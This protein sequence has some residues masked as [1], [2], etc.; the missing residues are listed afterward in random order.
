LII[1]ISGKVSD[2]FSLSGEDIRYNG[3]VISDIGI[4]GGD[5]LQ[6]S[7]DTETGHIID[8]KPFTKEQLE[9]IIREESGDYEEEE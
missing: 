9:A 8:W 6:M 7:I 4:G 5:Y 1:R 3:Y 2:M